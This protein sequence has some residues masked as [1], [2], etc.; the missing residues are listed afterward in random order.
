MKNGPFVFASVRSGANADYSTNKSMVRGLTATIVAGFIMAILLGAVAP[1]LNYT[2]RVFYVILIAV[3]VA[4]VGT[5][6]NQIWWEFSVGHVLTDMC[7]IVIGWEIAALF[8]AGLIK[9]KSAAAK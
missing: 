8:M 7:D 2:G 6:L 3:F 1:R 4:I 9:G 5:Y